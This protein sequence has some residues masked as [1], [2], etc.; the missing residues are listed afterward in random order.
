MKAV[1]FDLGGVV[2]G[3]PLHMIADYEVEQG[4]APG[5]INR[6]VTDAG[7][8]G[9]WSRFE[10][11]ALSRSEFVAVFEAECAAAGAEVDAHVIL[12][13]IDEVATPRPSMLAALERLR[14][15]GLKLAALTNNFRPLQVPELT[16]RFDVVVESSVEGYRKPQ[17]QIYELVLERLGVGA[18]EAVFLD[19]IGANLKPARSM[20]MTTIKVIDP[21]Q[22][23]AELEQVLG[24]RIT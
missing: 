12:Q 1:V 9:A 2:L 10:R 15:A 23:L 13:G 4:I 5:T 18:G 19:D 8:D 22:A 16:E 14:E 6:V 24:L 17:P 3:S 7:A 11:G 20:G 21:E